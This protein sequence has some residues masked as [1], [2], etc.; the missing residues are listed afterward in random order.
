MA[1]WNRRQ[2]LTQATMAS[3]LRPALAMGREGSYAAEYPDM[4]VRYLAN[5]TNALAAKWDAERERIRSGADVEARNHFV[6]EKVREMMHGLP[7]RTA[8]EPVVT[9]VLKRDGYRIEN[10]RFQSRPNFW[11]T[12]NLYVPAG[13]GPFPAVISPCGHSAEARIYRPYQFMYQGLVR[14][15]FVVLAYDPVGQGERRQFWNPLT[16][17]NEIGGP[18][19][20]EHSLP[21]QLL[22]LI[23][24]DL[25]NY[26]VWDGM[27][28]V[29]YLL[30][31]PEVDAQRIGCAGQSGGGTLTLFISAL[32]ERVKCA[33]V[34]EGGTRHRWPLSTRPE[35]RLGT[36]DTEQHFF[37]A[38]IYGV[39]LCD[40]HAAIAP[41]PLLATIEHNSPDFGLI[42]RHIR[43]R[44]E[45]L[46]AA[47]KFE[48]EI[49]G[50]PHGL[51]VKLRLRN[52]DWFCRW[53]QDRAG[54]QSEPELRAE[55][56]EDLHT[57][58]LG[59]I[60]YAQQ[61][62]TIYSVLWKRAA[63]LPPAGPAKADDIARLLRYR[64]PVSDVS[65]R[66]L[67]TTDR[68]GYR[69][70]KL[71]FL[72]EPGIYIPAWVFLSNGERAKAPAILYVHERGKE[73]DGLEFGA[74]EA[75]ARKGRTVMSVDV[76]GIGATRPA[77]PAD[78]STGFRHVDDAET[79]MTYWAWEMDESL[80]GMRVQDVVRSMDYLLSRNDVQSGSVDLVGRGMGAL[81]VLFAAALD[82]RAHAA[83]CEGGLL[84]YRTL[85][86]SDRYLHGAD[87]FIPDVLKHFDLPEV[88]S[89]VKC[90]VTVVAP[91]DA[92]K[93]PVDLGRARSTYRPPARVAP[94]AGADWPQRCLELLEVSM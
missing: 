74:L 44:Y 82:P 24:Q 83:V 73:A 46:G 16:R 94:A 29:D 35:T 42:T 15:G 77:H 63:S 11:V 36:G 21:G 60:R 76:R 12:G 84:S 8:L 28:A 31:R 59:S 81:W 22:L 58:A 25:T 87:I 71:E 7:E 10:L 18:V 54:P 23:G 45:Q 53:F 13:S 78:E 3:A 6:R 92:M 90:P 4:L 89:A 47:D 79:V 56:A 57:T 65:V 5:K 67:E 91:L 33:A 64:K 68:K 39:D 61:G 37:P 19:T 48:T 17:R 9:R 51:T 88:A 75:L 70:E 30:T 80:M 62:D 26:R 66:R 32:D 72:A 38:G 43:K 93:N 14:S 1:E 20:W 41:R 40:L 69:I 50:D 34:H 86:D 55:A 85:T 27:R 49:A 52:T 2:F